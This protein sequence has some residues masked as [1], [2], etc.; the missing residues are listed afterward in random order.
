MNACAHARSLIDDAL[1][2]RLDARARSDFDA[3]VRQCAACAA[4]WEFATSVRSSLLK[5]GFDP[6]PA[7]LRESIAAQVR[8]LGPRKTAP[9]RAGGLRSPPFL[10]AAAGIL[11]VVAIGW[12]VMRSRTEAPGPGESKV[13]DGAP[14]PA[15]AK[16]QSSVAKSKAAAAITVEPAGDAWSGAGSPRE[17][18]AGLAL[19]DERSV[20][21]LDKARAIALGGEAPAETLDRVRQAETI[22]WLEENLGAL[23]DRAGDTPA[24]R[25]LAKDADKTLAVFA[26][27]AK[28]A[29]EKKVDEA[30]VDAPGAPVPPAPAGKAENEVSLLKVTEAR[31][32]EDRT[33]YMVS[34]PGV[35][36][37]VERVL[38]GRGISFDQVWL[39]DQDPNPRRRS[40]DQ[41]ATDYRIVEAN[42]PEAI[43]NELVGDL[44]SLDGVRLAPVGGGERSRALLETAFAK[45]PAA[46][47]QGPG[48]GAGRAGAKAAQAAPP[49]S[50]PA[51]QVAA[52]T[53]P[54]LL[55]M[56]KLRLVLISR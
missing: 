20:E 42:V 47:L 49:E 16:E 48:G 17:V 46:D 51:P 29:G 56:R 41:A 8:A 31:Q 54:K 25:Q 13:R 35:F 28:N 3:H 2:G 33:S 43:L 38:V 7:G 12:V 14:A 19:G 39:K 4:E 53:Q 55:G 5:V 15:L 18:D 52:A 44:E 23:I 6:A 1:D 32:A 24:L 10:R 9:A 22:V 26:G 40:M 34:G 50:G 21:A 30:R 11:V 36:A 27:G 37:R 45:R